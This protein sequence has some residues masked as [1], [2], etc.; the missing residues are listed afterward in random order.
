MM[1]SAS[2]RVE[3]KPFSVMSSVRS[4]K[5]RS[6]KFIQD[7]AVRIS[8]ALGLPD[9]SGYVRLASA[10]P[11]VQPTSN[12]CYL[13][14][15]N[16]IRRVREGVRLATKLLESDAFQEWP[17]TGSILRMTFWP[18]MTPWISGPAKP[19]ARHGT[20]QGLV[21]WDRTGI[22]WWLSTNTAK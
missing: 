12:Y 7:D 10:D 3:A 1:A 6:T 15:R 4:R 22:Q 19:W 2:S 14:H 11:G 21:R 16:D 20:Y 9:G 8:C 18:T 5:K 13:Q 17:I